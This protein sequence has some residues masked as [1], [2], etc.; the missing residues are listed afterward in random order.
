MRWIDE[1]LARARGRTPRELLLLAAGVGYTVFELTSEAPCWPNVVMYASATIAF[2]LRFFPAR[3]IGVGVA[4][5]AL[6]QRLPDL[7][8]GTAELETPHLWIALA[9][10]A[11]LSSRDLEARFERAP[12]R[13]RW[14]PNAWAALPAADL[15][16]LRWCVYA[17][18]A[19][20]AGLGYTW[21][22]PFAD[23][24]VDPRLV[25]GVIGSLVALIALLAAGRAPALLLVPLVTLP[26]AAMLGSQVVEAEGIL[27]GR[28][29]PF[30]DFGLWRWPA[31]VLPG[32]LL[33]LLA[34]GLATP[35]AVRLLRRI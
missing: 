29:L 28:A 10:I 31:F 1:P 30:L 32:T 6:A 33:A 11:V 9:A 7:R 16:R 14:L 17:L 20:A 26:I 13:L 35:Y 8:Y 2:A 34:A 25:I 23:T 3:A 15:R 12:S 21:G 4:L 22:V 19:L 5:G 18:A 24:G 27:A